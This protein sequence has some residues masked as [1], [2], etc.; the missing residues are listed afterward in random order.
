MKEI[1]N[2]ISKLKM[3]KLVG[4]SLLAIAAVS[5]VILQTQGVESLGFFNIP[6]QLVFKFFQFFLVLFFLV[7]VFELIQIILA[8][9]IRQLFD[10]LKAAITSVMNL[11]F[12]FIYVKPLS[13][14][15]RPSVKKILKESGFYSVERSFIFLTQ[16]TQ[17]KGHRHDDHYFPE[18]F[19]LKN[20]SLVKIKILPKSTGRWRFGFKFSQDKNFS[21]SRYDKD[22]SLLHLTKD[23]GNKELKVHFYK[24]DKP[25]PSAHKIWINYNNEEITIEL[26]NSEKST[27][28]MIFPTQ[29]GGYYGTL[30]SRW[31][32]FQVFAWADGV[33]DF[34]IDAKI[35]IIS[36]G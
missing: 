29:K 4:A 30:L 19:E 1:L 32:Y 31:R 9:K 14:L 6:K 12:N 16:N 33:S 2:F 20:L 25:T 28:I 24:G 15:I 5:V 17:K 18:T 36:L 3:T 23:K 26:S 8:E 27:S 22:H 10:L 13:L 34:Q 35:Q 21:S 11:I 7:F